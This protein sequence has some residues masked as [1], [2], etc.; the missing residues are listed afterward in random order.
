MHMSPSCKLH[1]WVQNTECKQFKSQG[2]YHLHFWN[3]RDQITISRTRW[4][5]VQCWSRWINEVDLGGSMCDQMLRIDLYW[6]TLRY[7]IAHWSTLIGIAHWSIMSQISQCS[8]YRVGGEGCGR[9]GCSTKLFG[10]RWKDLGKNPD[11]FFHNI[12]TPP[13]PNDKWLVPIMT[14]LFMLR[15]PNFLLMM[16]FCFLKPSVNDTKHTNINKDII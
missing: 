8:K 16:I 15:L 1:R 9:W 2:L 7:L 14:Q 6:D 13:I 4:I 5:N 3:L 10:S 11:F 12:S